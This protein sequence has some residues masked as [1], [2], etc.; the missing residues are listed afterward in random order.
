MSDDA[1]LS[2]IPDT[3]VGRQFA[4]W[5]A[6]LNADGEG[7][8]PAD[9]DRFGPGLRD[10][11]QHLFNPATMDEAWRA[12]AG[13]VGHVVRLTVEQSSELELVAEV[14]TD[15][16][17]RHVL[18]FAVD[19]Q[20]PHQLIRF[21]GERRH[22]F[23]LSV[24]EATAADAAILADIERR[25][26]IVM[27]DTSVYIDRGAEY[28]ASTRLMEDCTI[29]IASVDGIP[30]AVSCGAEHRV[31]VGGAIKSMV[32][33]S[34]LRVLPEHQRKGLWGAANRVLEKY[35]DHVDGSNA[36]ISVDNLGMQHGFQNTPNKWGQIVQMACSWTTAALA[37]PPAGT[38][39]D[40]RTTRPRSPGGST[41][42]MGARKCSCPM[43]P[44]G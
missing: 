35:W 17:R 32:T 23:N 6:S 11:F 16:N 12:E 38:R 10:R 33:V 27:G 9:L 36:Y 31:L 5:I 18:R 22:D 40:A 25:C 8:T 34:H 26:P 4:W 1:L 3:P 13:Q 41:P 24:R 43:T 15:K 30:A 28:L 2:A 29:G 44:R 21:D 42:S 39:R 7:A 37:G 19:P 20:P 14:A